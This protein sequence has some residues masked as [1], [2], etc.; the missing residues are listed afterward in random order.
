MSEN[1]HGNTEMLSTGQ[2]IARDLCEMDAPLV[3][4][5][6]VDPDDVARRIDEEVDRLKSGV[7]CGDCDGSGWLQNRVEGRYPCTCMTEAEPYQII[8]KQR[9]ELL[10]ALERIKALPK[11]HPKDP[12]A[13]ANDTYL[14]AELAIANGKGTES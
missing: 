7:V 4:A 3:N 12:I 11:K 13:C 8:K 14:I 2:K 1:K 9:D 10:S 5:I 6:E